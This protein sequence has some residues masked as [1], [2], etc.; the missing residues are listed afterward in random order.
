MAPIQPVVPLLCVGCGSTLSYTDQIMCTKR[1]WGFG[2][3][4]PENA[5]FMN[6]LVKGA[7]VVGDSC[8]ARNSNLRVTAPPTYPTPLTASCFLSRRRYEEH[9][10]QGLMEM[11]DVH[12]KCGKQVGYKF[13]GDKTTTKRNLN[14]V[15][16]YG[17]VSS[18][19]SR[20]PYQLTR[21]HAAAA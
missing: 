15:G 17:L 4:A 3:G 13:C 10:A 11:A 5:C 14:Q 1:R 2:D 21:P 9:L 16:R 18:C 12:C 20:A 6:S 8:G 7:F 19:F